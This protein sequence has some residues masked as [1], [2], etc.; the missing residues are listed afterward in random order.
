MIRRPPKSPP[1]PSP[2]LSRSAA[3]GCAEETA[4]LLYPRTG[5]M[6]DRGY[7]WEEVVAVL[8]RRHERSG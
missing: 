3:A 1:F 8:R 4:A 7:G 6:Q 5:L 2:P